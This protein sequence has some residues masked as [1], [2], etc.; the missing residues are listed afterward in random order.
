M[1]DA[2]GVVTGAV[3]HGAVLRTAPVLVSGTWARMADGLP[4]ASLRPVE[5]NG[6]PGG[7]D[8]DAEQRLMAVLALEITG[9]RIRGIT[10]VVNPEKL[11]HVSG[12]T[13]SSR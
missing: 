2:G 13:D 10:A 12:F 8:L 5:V 3:V 11:R 6:A 4:G 7:V 1:D 9:G